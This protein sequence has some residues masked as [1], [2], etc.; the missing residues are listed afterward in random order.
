VNQLVPFTVHA[1]PTLIANVGEGAS[2]RFFEFFATQIRNQNTR[3][4]YARAA[5]EFFD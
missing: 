1:A 4:A 2:Y 5:K 3:R